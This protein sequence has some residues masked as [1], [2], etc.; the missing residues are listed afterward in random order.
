MHF[1]VIV[2]VG[3]A[4]AST[5]AHAAEPGTTA[6][7]EPPRPPAEIEPTAPQPLPVDV[8]RA[9]DDA[10]VA[11]GWSGYFKGSAAVGLAGGL[12]AAIV[13]PDEHRLAIVGGTAVGALL[14]YGISAAIDS[15]ARDTL[16]SVGVLP[17]APEP[18]RLVRSATGRVQRLD[19]RR[20]RI[21][22]QLEAIADKISIQSEIERRAWAACGGAHELGPVEITR[23][24]TAIGTA[25]ATCE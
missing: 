14:L 15:H 10:A 17:P 19:G 13:A 21:A 16:R 6:T 2:A 3:L 22:V 9:L 5:V 23:G 11:R 18:E 24:A 1:T 20:Y 4:L 7:V 8:L 12:V 25:V